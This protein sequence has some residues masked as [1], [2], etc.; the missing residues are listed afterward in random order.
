MGFSG[1]VIIYKECERWKKIQK[2]VFTVVTSLVSI[3]ALV[4]EN[5]FFLETLCSIVGLIR[6]LAISSLY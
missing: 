2:V 4:A 5:S 1:H 6:W 3:D